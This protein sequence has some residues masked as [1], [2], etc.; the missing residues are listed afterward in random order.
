M[1]TPERIEESY[2]LIS[3]FLVKSHTDKDDNSL[4][5]RFNELMQH[6]RDTQL[7]LDGWNR[8]GLLIQ[9]AQLVDSICGTTLTSIRDAV[10]MQN[11]GL[12]KYT[13]NQW[14]ESWEWCRDKLLAL[15]EQELRDLYAERT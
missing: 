6:M 14:N 12:A 11:R 10:A 3:G 4:F 2:A 8:A 7:H 1:L 13:G 9:K 15:S 5:V